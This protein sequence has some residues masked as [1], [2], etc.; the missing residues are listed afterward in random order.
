MLTGDHKTQYQDLER[1]VE[2]L[3][4]EKVELD[5]QNQR[6][7]V[8]DSLIPLLE[9]ELGR[10]TGSDDFDD[11]VK[12]NAL[13]IVAIRR[14]EEMKEE[15]ATALVRRHGDDLYARLK[16]EQGPA[17]RAGLHEKFTQDGTYVRE[18]ERVRKE[19]GQG[20][21]HELLAEQAAKVR[22]DL[23]TP[24]GREAY[25]ASILPE[26]ME[27]PEMAEVR[28]TIR[29]ELEHD[30]RT[31]ATA[32]AKKTITAEEEARE[33]DFKAEYAQTYMN[34][35]DGRNL[36]ERIRSR[37]EEKWRDKSIEEI[38]ALLEDEE[39]Q[40]LLGERAERAR[41]KLEKQNK[42]EALLEHFEGA[43]LDMTTI[44]EGSR[45]IV[46]LGSYGKKDVRQEKPYGGYEVKSVLSV[47]CMRKLEFVARGEGKFKV[48]TDSLQ[49]SDNPWTKAAT[50]PQGT[51]LT[52]GDFVSEN[53]V[54]SMTHTLTADAPFCYDTDSTDPEFTT[55]PVNVANIKIDGVSARKVENVDFIKT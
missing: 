17:I 51:I 52:I 46:Y 38:A 8:A 35:Y 6:L 14:T 7:R 15:M 39:L 1:R 22:A 2:E 37:L 34:T 36:R 41:I 28:S 32:E 45:L 50:L 54:L 33:E 29:H 30:W 11:E 55:T 42:A 53:G 18:E 19:F 5:Y 23:D 21:R 9:E 31:E 10:L 24:E 20:V 48:L 3:G 4:R 26:V 16:E 12:Q 44:S 13:G 40:R 27:S 43:G 49:D 25:K 47:T